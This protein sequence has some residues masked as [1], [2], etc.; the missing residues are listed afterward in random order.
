MNQPSPPSSAWLTPGRSWAL[1]VVIAACLFFIGLG[2]LPL[3]EPDE[4]RNAEVAREMVVSHDWIT[5]HYDS[6]PYLDKPILLF[7][8]IAGS[9][10]CFGINEF[11]ARFPSALA[12]LATVLLAGL[13]GKRMW[14]DKAGLRVGLILATSPL[15]L[16]FARFTIFDMALTFFVTAALLCFWLNGRRGF[17][18]RWL[19]VIAFA[20]MG[21]GTLTKGPVGFV[22]PLLALVV[23]HALAGNFRELKKLHWGSGWLVFLAITLPWFIAVSIHNPDFPKY[24]FWDESLLRFTTGAHM[25]RSQGVYYYIPVYLAGFFPWSFFLLFA[26]WNRLKRWRALRHEAHRAELFLLSWAGIVFVFFTVSH[27]KLPGYFLPALIPLSVLMAVAWRDLELREGERAPDWLTAGFAVMIFLGII[28]AAS[29]QILR[30]HGMEA[31]LTK[32]LPTSVSTLIKSA[33]FMGGVI[34]A[35]LGFLGRNMVVRSRKK[36]MREL[37]FAI[38]ALTMPLLLV[39]WILPIKNYFNAF[40]SHHLV[41]AILES[42]QR[43]LPVYGYYY[44][45]T[46]LPF[47]LK[48]PVG[49]VT[50]DGDEITSNYVVSR[51]N[52]VRKRQLRFPGQPGTPDAEE[53]VL[54]DANQL[55]SLSRSAPGAFLLMVQNNEVNEA[56][57]VAGPMRPLWES[58][59]YSIWEKKP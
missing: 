19:D 49:L 18:S 38:A 16:G 34:V 11:A 55:A 21:A 33:L 2:R 51:F 46:S 12:A 50:S 22:I 26:G 58:W 6:L 28:M 30:L 4:G 39:R 32:K 31:H 35:A 29:P 17:T 7:W 8:M 53:P 24:A 42:P 5:P 56:L 3:L 10:R 27:S 20:A 14:G 57:Q 40:S 47:Y 15:I 23:F 1:L 45:R 13:I 25:H 9:F 37:A 52:E 44:F 48:R 43:N 41:E 54:I 59:K 36:I